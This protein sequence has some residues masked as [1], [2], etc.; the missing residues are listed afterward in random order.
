MNAAT[1]SADPFDLNRFLRAQEV[2]YAQA[3]S[4]IS[5]GRKRTHWMWFI[6][7]QIVGLGSSEMARRFAINSIAEAEAYLRHPVLG[8]RL[9][10]CAAAALAAPGRSAREIFGQPDDMKLRSSATLF[11][12]VSPAESVFHRLLDRFF[13]GEGDPRTLQLLNPPMGRWPAGSGA[14]PAT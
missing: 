13:S 8:P 9:V 2:T 7:P 11:A 4:E 5:S 3:L 1:G 14:P 6:F 10:E 12:L